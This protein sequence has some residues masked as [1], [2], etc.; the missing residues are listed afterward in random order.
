MLILYVGESQTVHSHLV[1][2]NMNYFNLFTNDVTAS[3]FSLMQKMT[4]AC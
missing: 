1:R 3:Y 4:A 2:Y